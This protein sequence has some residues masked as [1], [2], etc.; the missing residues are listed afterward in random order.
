M[1]SKRIGVSALALTM[2][3][4]GTFLSAGQVPNPAAPGQRAGGRGGRGQSDPWPGKKKLLVVADVQTGYHHD[5]INHGMAVI[6]QLGRQSGAYVSVLRTDSELI[7]KQPIVGQGKYA[8]SN[9]NVRPLDFYDALLLLPSGDGTM[10]DQQKKDLLAFVRDDGKGLIV[11]HAAGVAFTR[12]DASMTWPE[13]GDLIGGLMDRVDGHAGEFRA[14]AR[15][16]VEDTNFPGAM[17][18]GSSTFMFDEQHPVLMPPYSRDKVH[19]IMRLDPASISEPQRAMR[20][21]G[22]FPVVWARQYGKGRVFNVGWGELET[23]Y[24]NPGFQK[25]LLEGIKWA[26]GSVP[27]DVTPKPMSKAAAAGK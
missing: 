3:L 6:E 26:L 1:F 23:T 21:D 14:N 18:F 2:V 19:V 5:A 9:I 11:G 4:C 8:G 24:D 17:A 27:A 13:W 25:M 10:S 7:T 12:K 20:P 22:D 16:I 15:I